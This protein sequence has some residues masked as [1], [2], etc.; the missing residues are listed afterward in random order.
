MVKCVVG[1]VCNPSRTA[2]CCKQV[3]DPSYASST[4]KYAF[5]AFVTVSVY[6]LQDMHALNFCPR[7]MLDL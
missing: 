3:T 7:F 1:D 5:M 2:L 6:L 4:E